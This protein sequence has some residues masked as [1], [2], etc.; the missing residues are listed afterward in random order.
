MHTFPLLL[1]PFSVTIC[2][3][4]FFFHVNV[5]NSSSFLIPSLN[6]LSSVVSAI[7]PYTI[8]AALFL[9]LFYNPDLFIDYISREVLRAEVQTREYIHVQIHTKRTSY[10]ST[11]HV[12]SAILAY[13]YSPFS[14]FSEYGRHS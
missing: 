3:S 8:L 7:L 6:I 12:L 14:C 2:I 13:A 1:G 10:P 9:F 4:F 11:R 5:Q